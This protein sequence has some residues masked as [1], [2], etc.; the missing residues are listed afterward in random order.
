MFVTKAIAEITPADNDA[1][2]P[3]GA[4]EV[5]LSAPTLDRDGDTLHS[6]EWKQPLP[7][8]IT[9]D[10]DHGMTVATTIGSGAPR[11]EDDGTLRVSGTYSSLPRGQ[12]VRTLV[13][14][15]HIR[16][17]SVA[18][19]TE[20]SQKDSKPVRELLNGAFV[21]VPSNREAVVLSSKGF[22]VLEEETKAGAR[23]SASDQ[24][25]IQA[26]HDAMVALGAKCAADDSDSEDGKSLT[27]SST[28]GGPTVTPAGTDFEVDTEKAVPPDADADRETDDLTLRAASDAETDDVWL[29]AAAI[30]ARASL[31]L[32]D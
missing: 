9:F 18:F 13:N 5:I 20:K 19:M 10:M 14:E 1:E 16:T 31:A 24:K 17:T 23:N 7:D 3:S 4:F 32:S 12:E 21:A 30:Q 11:I 8:H 29:R 2:T 22:E 25:S 26:A 6:D 28:D 15:G 27:K